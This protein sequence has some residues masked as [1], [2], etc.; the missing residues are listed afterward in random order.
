MTTERPMPPLNADELQTLEGWLD[1]HRFTLASKC[2][3]L[4]DAQAATPSLSP[5]PLTLMGLVQHLSEV[6][7]AWFRVLF[8]GEELEPI[9]GPKPGPAAHDG[10]F[11]IA[12]GATLSGALDTWRAEVAACRAAVADREPT[13]IVPFMGQEVTLRWVYAHLIEEYARHNGHADLLREAIDG[14]TGV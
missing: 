11:D 14:T 6:E 9:Y 3:G 2:E 10:G 13:D 8:A 1:F 4:D 12:E 7:R 5:S